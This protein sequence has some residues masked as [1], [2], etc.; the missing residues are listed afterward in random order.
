MRIVHSA[1]HQCLELQHVVFHF[2]N[3]FQVARIVNF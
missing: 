2:Q 3:G 1:L